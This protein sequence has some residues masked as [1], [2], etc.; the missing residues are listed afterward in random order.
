M[1]KTPVNIKSCIIKEVGATITKSSGLA[2]GEEKATSSA[3]SYAPPRRVRKERRGL[4]RDKKKLRCENGGAD[5]NDLICRF[6][7]SVPS[8]T[9]RVQVDTF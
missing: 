1:L 9:F 7:E 2:S 3:E 5:G 8:L 4:K 6:P